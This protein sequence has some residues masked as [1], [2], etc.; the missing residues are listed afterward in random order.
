MERK[1]GT[2]ELR[3]QL[4]DV[5]LAVK[6]G[7]A[8]YIIETFERSQAVLIS[9]EEYRQF[10]RF[11]KEREAFFKWLEETSAHNAER[12]LELSQEQVLAIIEQA[13]SAAEAQTG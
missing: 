5:L 9:L 13:R 11:K 6:E 7:R 10:Q 3:Q 12:N 2:T 8:A 1:I 4:T